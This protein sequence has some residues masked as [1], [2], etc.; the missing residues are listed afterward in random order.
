MRM[1]YETLLKSGALKP[2][3]TS[4]SQIKSRLD[5]TRRDICAAQAMLAA[6]ISYLPRMSAIRSF[7]IP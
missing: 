2:F 4:P 1:D 3:K 5:L 7:C 6:D